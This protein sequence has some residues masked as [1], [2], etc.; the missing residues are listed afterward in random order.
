MAGDL[1]TPAIDAVNNKKEFTENKGETAIIE[2][3]SVCSDCNKKIAK[4]TAVEV[5]D[6]K[7]AVLQKDQINHA[8]G[9]Y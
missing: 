5:V 1:R 9:S 4:S 8:H 7:I 3:Q 6:G 2:I